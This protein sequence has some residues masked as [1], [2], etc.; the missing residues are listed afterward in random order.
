M[1]AFYSIGYGGLARKLGADDTFGYSRED[2]AKANKKFDAILDAY[3]KMEYK[4]ICRLLKRNGVYATTMPDPFLFLKTL[5]VQ[6]F[7][8]KKLTSSNMRSKPEDIKE[9]ERLFLEKKLIPVIENYFTLDKATEAFRLAEYG[10]PR[11]KII[12]RV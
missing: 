12:V 2:L 11:G 7:F 1:K 3:G 4:D 5:I 6:L 9:M 8:R 10:K